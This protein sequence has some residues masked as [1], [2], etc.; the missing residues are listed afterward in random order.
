MLHTDLGRLLFVLNFR[1][2]SER[3]EKGLQEWVFKSKNDFSR[4][5]G[6]IPVIASVFWVC[7]CVCVCG[8][9]GWVGRGSLDHHVIPQL[10]FTCRL[11]LHYN[12][13]HVRSLVQPLNTGFR[14]YPEQI[15][16]IL[17]FH[18][19]WLNRIDSFKYYILMLL[20]Q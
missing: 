13:L 1:A 4:M 19:R 12:D 5:Y 3:H 20:L 17:L 6:L 2:L 9:G 8:K 10:V 18:T 15:R 14:N 11:L 7:V 16:N